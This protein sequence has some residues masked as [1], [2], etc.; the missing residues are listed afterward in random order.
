MGVNLSG[1]S[2]LTHHKYVYYVAHVNLND[3]HKALSEAMNAK[4]VESEG[5][6]NGIGSAV[7]HVTL[8]KAPGK[9][10]RSERTYTATHHN[11]NRLIKGRNSMKKKLWHEISKFNKQANGHHL[12]SEAIF[13]RNNDALAKITAHKI[14]FNLSE[15]SE[16]RKIFPKKAWEL[17]SEL[18]H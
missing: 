7:V 13:V 5:P 17:N 10:Y 3:K 14:T 1:T 8:F 6:L 4:R 15:L 2:F 16:A 11:L 9:R 18:E 12:D